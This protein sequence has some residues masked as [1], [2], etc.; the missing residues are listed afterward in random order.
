VRLAFAI[1]LG[2]ALLALL[3][4]VPVPRLDAPRSTVVLDRDGALL[5]A[6]VARDEQWRFAPGAVPD[7][8]AIA[9]QEFEDRRFRIHPGVDPIA[10]LRAAIDNA[11]EG[12]V[13]SGGSTLT[14][15]VVRLS[16][17][18][19]PRTVPQKIVEVALALRLELA[20]DKE[21]IL[22]AYAS[23]APFGGNTV[24]LE[25]AAWRLF[26]R[27]PAEL[28]WA[29]ACTLA[30]LPNS[31]GLVHA[32]RSREELRARRDRLLDRL[33][34]DGSISQQDGALAKLEAVPDPPAAVPA[35][36]PHL[37]SRAPAGHTT[38]TT[39]DGA[40]QQR[41][42][43]VL[44]QHGRRLAGEGIHNAAALVVDVRTGAVLAY[45][46]NLPLPGA[47]HENHVD[48]VQ[49]RRSTGSTL[50]PFLYAA[51]LQ[52]GELLP[53]EIVPDVP[54][55]L[56]GFAPENSDRSFDGALPASDALARSRNVPAAWMLRSHGVERFVDD[57]RSFGM[58][59]LD[60][61]PDHYGLALILG[62][63]EGTLW[64][65][66]SMFRTLA[67]ATVAADEPFVGAHWSDPPAARVT[68]PIDRGAAWLTLNALRDVRRPG[69]HAA[70]EHY[71]S[72]RSIAWK[73][74]TSY[75]FRDAWAIGV[76][77]EV[78]I[79]V[80]AGNADGEGRPTLT[81]LSAA[82]PILFDLVDLLPATGWFPTP[83][84]ALVQVEV[85]A[86][87]GMRAGADCGDTLWE[88]VPAAGLRE[89][90]CS[91]CRVVHTDGAHRV[92]AGC[93]PLDQLHAEPWFVLP[94]AMEAYV[95]ARDAGHRPLPPWREDCVADGDD[96]AA[97]AIVSP[98]P[99]A[100]VVV[101]RVLDGG[102]KLVLEATHRD[103]H[104]IV[105]WHLD[106]T[107][108]ATTRRPHQVE[109]A[110]GPGVHHLV[111]VDASGER[112]ERT[113][114]VIASPGSG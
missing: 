26:G 94:P 56:G 66:T 77:P 5:G 98:K 86:H 47:P 17:G 13:V 100:A 91:Y 89:T 2:A 55:R 51:M 101:P 48:V 68:P 104:A 109:V 106:E 22:E 73:T 108:L 76:T 39:I 114:T 43:A 3:L 90:G 78:A 70:G 36:T 83:D 14:M 10:I 15:Q 1:D 49:A 37:L 99:H 42:T 23:L 58:T 33:V 67:W 103:P 24:G 112:Q 59:T 69:V 8:Y 11:R 97:L 85:C 12:R 60:R 105:H 28:S 65:L 46:G 18:N 27:S 38:R 81:G 95:A 113:F 21:A 45:V 71:G 54:M 79:G 20:F 80:W 64:D 82:A 93:H 72:H 44:L 41:A 31:P 110:P 25:A 16:R 111:A 29:E 53:H 92:H 102:G 32:G 96:V 50:K 87:S 84:G 61:P 9:L 30:V 107:F 74:G 62:G 52:D 75:G 63:A 7:R 35:H 57:L 34:A 88:S 6:T 4:L 19:P 40:L